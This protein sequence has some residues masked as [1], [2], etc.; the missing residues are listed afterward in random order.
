M[1]KMANCGKDILLAR[2]GTEQNQRFIEALSPESVKLN[3]FSLKDWML[4]AY[5][6]ASHVNY[7][8][9]S[10][11]KV[12]DGNWQS[13]FKSTD[14]IASFLNE[15]EEGNN[16]PPH[17]ALFIA[18]VKLLEISQDRFNKLST[19]HL[20]FYYKQV[21]K[22]KKQA[23]TPDKVHAIFELAKNAVSEKIAKSTELDAGKDADSKK[24]IFKTTDELIANQTTVA[25]LKSLYND[26]DNQ[27]LKAAKVAN[28]YDGEGGDFPNKDIKWWP[29]GY[30][31]SQNTLDSREYPELEGAQIGFALS[32]EILDLQEGQ[33]NIQIGIVFSSALENTIGSAGLIDSLELYCTGEKGWL[34]PFSVIDEIKNPND[35]VLFSSGLN[36][37][38]KKLNIAFQ[39]PKEE[40]ALVKYDVK[41]HAE[42]YK[43]DFPV[44]RVLFK[45]KETTGHQLYRHLIGN[46][47]SK[48]LVDVNVRGIQSL[49]LYNDIGIL[50]ADKPFH[51]FGIQPVKKSKFYIDYEEL[52]KK[53]WTDLTVNVEWKNTPDNFKSWYYAY[54]KTTG[55]NTSQ[56]AFI[57]GIYD[58][59]PIPLIA[60]DSTTVEL[61]LEEPDF[62]VRKDMTVSDL[63]KTTQ[64]KV[65]E[66][67]K[68]QL[69]D[70]PTNL[71]VN[72][73]NHFS[74]KA[75]IKAKEEW[76]TLSGKDTVP[77]FEGPSE[78]IFSLGLTLSNP[79][80]GTENI[81]PVRLSLNQTF[82]HE[83]YPRLYALAMS[84]E[85]KEVIIP[86]EPYTPFI[87]QLT[88]DY[89][90]SAEISIE[91]KQYKTKDFDLYHEHPFGQANEC[92][93]LKLE[94]GITDKKEAH[95]L[96]LLP[97]YCAGGELYIG[98]KNALNEQTV[99]LLIQVLEGSENPDAESFVGKQKVE[100][101]MLCNNE[102]K[103]LDS[104]SI[105]SN[106]TDN[107][108]RSGILSIAIPKEATN[109]N[110]LL[111]T[112][113]MWLK[114]RIHKKYNAV[115]KAISI[116][117]QAVIAE[118]SDNE[119]NLQHLDKGL[120]AETISK[121]VNR[122]PK[123]KGITQPYNSFGGKPEE[124]SAAYY[125]RISERLRHKNRAI[126]I[127]DYEHLILQNFPEIH[128]VKCLSHTCSKIENT[129]RKT[130]YLAPGSVVLVVIPDIVNKNVFDIYQPRVSTATLNK[131]QD[132]LNKLNSPLIHAKVI[133]PEYE[134]LRIDLKVQ[135][136]KGFDDVYYKV[137]LKNDLTRLLS[138]WAFD[139]SA[140]IPFG[141]SLHKS[142]IINYVENLKYVDFVSDVKLFQQMA[143]NDTETEV[144]SAVPTSP[145]SIL[146]SSK[147]H[148]VNDTINSCI[149]EEIVPAETCQ[150]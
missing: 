20:D 106:D 116:N 86:N 102:W 104:T 49:N 99:S 97:T 66:I 92:I 82:L 14:E 123:V 73:N 113:Y 28:S 85:D 18:F 148:T 59:I 19:R 37:T 88:L 145:E 89:N 54:R 33:R 25:S 62:E 26:H 140:A 78:E 150:K 90:A 52:Y 21:L 121:M 71:I 69:I 105:I 56:L 63:T 147:Q 48:V 6:F 60:K 137:V 124:S 146:V 34:G 81:G 47:F 23:A 42:N 87:E 79:S 35:S 109:N 16:I 149:N 75:E 135:F 55:F 115:S 139:N 125:R 10:N 40:G 126:T 134:E 64:T 51:P 13:F 41:V 12:S 117:A 130:K 32:G 67:I 76:S 131:I 61:N 93:S 36:S 120:S 31:E 8:D 144:N 94:N 30:F 118:F 72:G 95:K 2:E 22:V 27:K 128:K 43:S 142:V 112:G 38:R 80:A 29:F 50:N 138:P 44:F 96:N 7:F 53:K 127:W 141:L 119:N 58:Q 103:R 65:D 132:F 45:T 68:L 111:P 114:A 122:I 4:F 84:S 15:V 3:D 101:W 11:D 77:M 39:I 100:W 110:T 17:L 108:L 83:M 24:L 136:Q 91:N 133:N 129:K 57:K 5:N 1:L 143:F 46:P 107:L 9:V 74:A 70:E 98:L